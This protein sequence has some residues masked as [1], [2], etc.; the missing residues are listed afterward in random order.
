[1]GTVNVGVVGV[2]NC[3]SSL[4]QGVRFYADAAGAPAGL[5]NPVCAGYAVSDV[6]FTSAFDVNTAKIGKDLSAAIWAPPNNARE[7][8]DVPHLGVPVVEGVL[9]D[10]VGRHCADRIDARGGATLD[11]VVRHLEDTD[12][13]VVVN[14]LP[15]GSQSASEVYAEAAL[16]AGCAFVNCIPAVIARSPQWAGRFEAAGLP[17][18]GDDLKSQ[19]GS[20]LVHRALL[21]V[22]A[23]NGV[24]LRNTYQ[25][26]SGG[27]MDFLNMQDAD[28]MRSKKATKAAGMSA[29]AGRGPDIAAENVHVGADYVPFLAD[30]KVAFIRVEGEAFGGT[31]LELDLRLSVEDSPSAAGN[32][33]D[34]VRYMKSA[35]DRGESGVIDP[36]AALLMKAAPR[37]G[38]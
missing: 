35:L 38:R 31:P 21:D 37:P 23:A 10:G 2:G 8:A 13:H 28:R 4:V 34:A 22:L 30:R 19:F 9:G 18:I 24:R 36:I 25:L 32:V 5:M 12:T 6:V 11:D 17:L 1:M 26:N 27:N 16:R 7:F 33:L 29:G 15:V 20:T 14:F 3:V